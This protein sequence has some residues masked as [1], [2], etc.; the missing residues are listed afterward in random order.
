ME[1]TV[2]G[3]TNDSGS[4]AKNA[5]AQVTS[6]QQVKIL[7]ST[8]LASFTV[9]GKAKMTSTPITGLVDTE[10]TWLGLTQAFGVFQAYYTRKDAVQDGIVHLDH[11]DDR[12]VVA[13]IGSLGNGGIIAVFAVLYYP[14]LPQLG[15]YVRTL[16]WIGTACVVVGFAAAAASRSVS[17]PVS[18]FWGFWL[19][20]Y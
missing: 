16:C 6:S 12:A 17:L 3:S 2:I 11:I 5:G 1:L 4:N 14:R 8:S 19:I 13:A 15:T 7:L 20:A 10:L 9:I 18:S